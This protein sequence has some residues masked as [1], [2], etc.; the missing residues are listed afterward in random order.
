[1][2]IKSNKNA[3]IPFIDVVFNL[4]INLTLKENL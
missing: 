1:M 3:I 4:K 2:T